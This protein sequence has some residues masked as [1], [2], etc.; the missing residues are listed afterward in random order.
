MLSTS[1]L[2]TYTTLSHLLRHLK[3]FKYICSSQLT[4]RLETD[5]LVKPHL[6][7]VFSLKTNAISIHKNYVPEQHNLNLVSHLETNAAFIL[8]NNTPVLTLTSNLE[9]NVASI[10]KNDTPVKPDPTLVSSLETNAIFILDN[11]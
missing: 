6:P 10:R 2:P 8:E 7:L 1:T 5:A 3:L 4:Y 11:N 9:T